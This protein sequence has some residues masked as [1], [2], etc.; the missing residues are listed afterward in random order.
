M[1]IEILNYVATE[2]KHICFTHSSVV[3]ISASQLL[4]AV[5][6]CLLLE[7]QWTGPWKVMRWPDRDRDL[8]KS[9]SCGLRCGLGTDR[10]W[11][12]GPVCIC[13]PIQCWS[14]DGKVHKAVYIKVCVCVE[15][16]AERL[17][18]LYVFYCIFCRLNVEGGLDSF[19]T[20]QA[21]W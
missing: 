3:Y 5:I 15:C 4:L 9:S 14:F 6:F 11:G 21:R 10:S 17:C 20:L 16:Y 12:G 13:H 19:D 1:Q 18:S 8:N 7:L 2:V